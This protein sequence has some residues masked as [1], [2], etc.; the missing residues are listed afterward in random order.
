MAQV[1]KSVEIIFI[2][3]AA[4]ILASCSGG[5]VHHRRIFFRMDTVTEITI[6]APRTFNP[7]PVWRAVDSLLSESERRFSVTGEASEVRALNERAAQALPVSFELGEMLR[8]GL[9][10]G[11]SLDGAFDI[12][13]LPLKEVWGFCEQCGGDGP[14]PDSGQ[15]REAAV[16]VDYRNV[17]V[18]GAGDSVFFETPTARVDVGGIA[19]GFVLKRLEELLTGMGVKNFLIAAGGDILASGR[20]RDG[21][22]WRV[23]VRHPKNGSEL[24]ATL[25]MERGVLVTSGDYER[26]RIVDGVRYH[27]IFNPA[28]G[29]S[30]N[31]NQSVT[32]WA[33]DPIRGDVL[34]TGLFCRNARDIIG[35]A[36]ERD[37]IEC[38][39]VDSAGEIHVSSSLFGF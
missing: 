22:P 35:Y 5:D 38:I 19:K 27:H 2:C 13:V 25:P 32:I 39:V 1:K 6:S 8:A 10:Y 34:S 29:Y 33:D 36:Q 30:C 20:K 3:T 4:L 11:D 17:R 9:A 28:T 23:G 18:N 16:V 37:G 31:Q 7:K 21:T 12:T 24:I 14:L 15:V 26:Y